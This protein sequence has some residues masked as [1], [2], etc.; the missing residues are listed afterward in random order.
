M[1]LLKLQRL[2]ADAGAIKLYAKE[3]APNDNSKNQPY[4]SRDLQALNIFPTEEIVSAGTENIKAKLNFWWLMPDGEISK[5]PG[6]QLIWYPRHREFRLSG[7]I[8]G[9]R[10]NSPAWEITKTLMTHR[11]EGR[12]LFLGVTGDARVLGFVA[13]GHSE[14]ATEFRDNLPESRLGIFYVIGLPKVP[15][16]A[17]SRR[18]LLQELRRIHDL[19]WIDSKQLDSS[20]RVDPCPS[21]NCGGY[22]LEAELGIPKNG[23]ATPD[24]MG[25]EVKQ[26]S[27]SNFSRPATGKAITLMTPEPTGGFY[28]ENGAEA[29]VRRF[30]Y[31]DKNGVVDR[32]NFG[33][34]YRMGCRV[35]STG[36]KLQFSGYDL[37]SKK[38]TDYSGAIHLL[39]DEDVVAASWRFTDIIAH[40][41]RKHSKAVYVPSMRRIDP[42]NGSVQLQYCYGE[43]VRLAQET[44]A[45][46]LFS[47]IAAGLI[48][49]DPAI[50]VENA[51]S[52]NSNKKVRNQW[53]VASRN[54]SELYHIQETVRV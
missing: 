39:N 6:T 25:W 19:G 51:S 10:C 22:T 45:L 40:W 29:F 21:S 38:I 44:D 13:D 41:S 15:D 20:G 28:G 31:A 49:Y 34:V 48:Y 37:E 52:S 7:F 16:E 23:D 17:S 42:R 36:L 33:G 35:L 9:C 47:A 32:L 8:Q 18:M 11:S 24:F 30:G 54:V 14:L 1:N 26:H 27:V 53:R 4:L 5:A 3:L 2:F 46:M 50:K 12:I 43:I